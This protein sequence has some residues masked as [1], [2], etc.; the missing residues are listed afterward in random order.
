MQVPFVNP[1]L[2]NATKEFVAVIE[3]F[4]ITLFG[5]DLWQGGDIPAIIIFCFTAMIALA[6]WRIVS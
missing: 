2:L 5:T 1:L 3:D 6:V 4:L